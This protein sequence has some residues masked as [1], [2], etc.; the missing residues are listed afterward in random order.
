MNA[1]FFV[2]L[3]ANRPSRWGL[4][5]DSQVSFEVSI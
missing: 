1:I 2:G 4:T 3:A 5:L